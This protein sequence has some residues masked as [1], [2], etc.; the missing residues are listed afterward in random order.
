MIKYEYIIG[1]DLLGRP[2]I[3]TH[4]IPVEKYIYGKVKRDNK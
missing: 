4:Y 2:L 1:V 3:V